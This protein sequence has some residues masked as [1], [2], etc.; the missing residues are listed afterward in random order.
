MQ[1]VIMRKELDALAAGVEVNS[2]V[3]QSVIELVTGLSTQIGSL[4]DDPD[5]L[6]ELA[7]NLR[8]S[9]A[10]F[11]VAVAANT[12]AEEEGS[13]KGSDPALG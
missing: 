9:A 3:D 1:G 6:Q 11:A 13:R 10:R 7:D 2:T 4:K 8:D 5:K 12:P